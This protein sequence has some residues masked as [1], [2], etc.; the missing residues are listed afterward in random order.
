MSETVRK[1][2]DTNHAI[3]QFIARYKDVPREKI[4]KVIIDGMRKV[5]RD[6]QD[7]PATYL[8]H[9]VSTQ[10][11]VVFAWERRGDPRLDDGLNHAII[12]TVLPRRD[13]HYPKKR[14]DIT[15][16]VEAL[17][18]EYFKKKRISLSE[19]VDSGETAI[20]EFGKT[21]KF[22][23]VFFEGELYSINATIIEVK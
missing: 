20:A 13:K 23:V 4:N 6:Y 22:R 7:R 3:T 11:G 18:R 14:T 21:R 9:S 16:T 8:V 2:I 15:L 10:I 17:A 19:K 1:I 12:I 5:L